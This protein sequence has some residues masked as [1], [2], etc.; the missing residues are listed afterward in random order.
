M[1]SE[2]GKNKIK[3]LI[4]DDEEGFLI[5]AKM[6]L[7]QIGGF[8]VK[9]LSCAKGIAYHVH[10]FKPDIILLDILMPELNGL[11]VCNIL[12]KDGLGKTTPIII[13]SALQTK[14]DQLNAYRCGVVDYITK[15][16]KIEEI[17]EKIKKAL[18]YK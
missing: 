10:T 18:R 4:V 14:D 5:V 17:V 6:N 12:N 7:E 8:E 13:I 1:D 9:T 15:P 16:A 3:V 11:E 2:K